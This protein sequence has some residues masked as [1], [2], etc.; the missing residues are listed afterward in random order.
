[1]CEQS[2][3]WNCIYQKQIGIAPQPSNLEN[4]R[5]TKNFTTF[6]ITHYMVTC[7]WWRLNAGSALSPPITHHVVSCDKSCESFCDI[8]LLTN[9][10]T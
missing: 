6:I 1:M 4:V 8:A 5:N 9:L 2:E 10:S 3:N 7:K